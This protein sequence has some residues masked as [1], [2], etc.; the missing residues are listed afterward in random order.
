M[1][2][3]GSRQQAILDTWGRKCTRVVFVA[4]GSNAL[5]QET[6]LNGNTSVKYDTVHVAT[7][8]KYGNVWKIIQLAFVHIYST[9]WN[10]FDWF[11]RV[12]DDSYVIMENLR[13]Y[14]ADKNM[15]EP[16]FHG[17]RLKPLGGF[18]TGGPGYIMS[19]DILT[20]LIKSFEVPACRITRQTSEEDVEVTKCL[21]AVSGNSLQ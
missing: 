3:H 18:I 19:R 14:L 17:A 12:D 20:L 2:T 16:V 10:D 4:A 7:S 5:R 8:Q 1:D 6:K 11:F 13:H 9:F 21:R 15:S